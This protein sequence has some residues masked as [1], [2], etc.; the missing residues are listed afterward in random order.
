MIE[1][2]GIV[3]KDLLE[4]RL[5]AQFPGYQLSEKG[6]LRIKWIIPYIGVQGML[7]NKVP[8]IFPLT[9]MDLD[10][11]P[12]KYSSSSAKN[13]VMKV[14]KGSKPFRKIFEKTHDFLTEERLNQWRCA[15]PEIWK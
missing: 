12:V 8:I 5:Q 3:S 6:Y 9:R 1:D 15:P 13:M 14:K 11:N 4:D 7:H 10:G 2:G